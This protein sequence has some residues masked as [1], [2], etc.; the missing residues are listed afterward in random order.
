MELKP[1]VRLFKSQAKMFVPHMDLD[2]SKKWFIDMH[3]YK[4]WFYKNGNLRKEDVQNMLKVVVDLVSEKL[5]IDDS[6]FW[7]ARARKVQSDEQYM[8]ITV[9]EFKV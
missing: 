6:V 5:G 3:V 2:V 9:G 7:E 1:E 8:M 4:D